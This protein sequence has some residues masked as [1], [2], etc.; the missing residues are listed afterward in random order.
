MTKKTATK[1]PSAKQ[2]VK[3]IRVKSS[4]IQKAGYEPTRRLLVIVL[5]TGRY[6]AF[7]KVPKKNW[8]AFVAAESK[9]RYFNLVLKPN[10]GNPVGK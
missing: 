10:F 7:P 3:L 2:S 8:N 1:K 5:K 9:G 6:I 4:F